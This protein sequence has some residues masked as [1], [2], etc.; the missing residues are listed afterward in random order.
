MIR[1]VKIDD[2]AAI[3]DIYNYYIINTVISF[4]EEPLSGGEMA[5]RIREISLKYPWFVWE[6]PEGLIGYAYVNKW[7]ERIAYRRAAELSIYLKKG[8]EGKGIGGRLFSHL[9]EAVKKTDIHALVSGIT[10]PNER[11]VA[12]H[13]K[14]G[15]KKIA[16][17]NEIGFKMDKWLDV[18]YWELILKNE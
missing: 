3:H 7:K 4:E 2:A 16:Q 1:P 8:Y 14:F 17:F 13:E 10:L 5:E 18:G 6:D 9:L 15:F 11:S 12:L